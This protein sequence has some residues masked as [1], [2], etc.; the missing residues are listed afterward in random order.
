[1]KAIEHRLIA[2]MGEI[3]LW[4]QAMNKRTHDHTFIQRLIKFSSGLRE[5]LP[6]LQPAPPPFKEPPFPKSVNSFTP[7]LLD[8]KPPLI[9]SRTWTMNIGY[10]I[11]TS[12]AMRDLKS[13]Q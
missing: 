11:F 8:C 10:N 5:V 3:V 4:E 9:V 6:G 1:M 12:G 7:Y 13:F 2:I